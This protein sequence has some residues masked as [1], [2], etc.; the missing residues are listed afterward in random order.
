MVRLPHP[1]GLPWRCPDPLPTTHTPGREVGAGSGCCPQ[2]AGTPWVDGRGWSVYVGRVRVRGRSLVP[3]SPSPG[4]KPAPS[5]SESPHLPLKSPLGSGFNLPKVLSPRNKTCSRDTMAF[6]GPDGQGRWLWDA[7]TARC[8][9]H[10]TA[11][12]PGHG[13][14]AV[15]ARCRGHGTAGADSG[16][17]TLTP[18]A[19]LARVCA[20]GR[21]PGGDR[22]GQGAGHWKGRRGRC[23]PGRGTRVT[24]LTLLELWDPVALTWPARRAGSGNPVLPPR[25]GAGRTRI[26]AAAAQPHPLRGAGGTRMGGRELWGFL[27]VQGPLT[28]P[29]RKPQSTGPRLTGSEPNPSGLPG[30][31]RRAPFP[32]GHWGSAVWGTGT[33]RDGAKPQ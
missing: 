20:S 23:P 18:R 6:P 27:G 29:H 24:L 22:Q 25:P 4:P 10:G 7:V 5:G 26:P 15:T 8:R 12:C 14:A 19:A 2:P 31:G 17:G 1:R 28:P 13:T 33:G 3:P 30:G 16:A 21:W 11:R 32:R 9:G